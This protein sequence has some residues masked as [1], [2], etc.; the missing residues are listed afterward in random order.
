MCVCWGGGW[1]GVDWHNSNVGRQSQQIFDAWV[2]VGMEP[3][4]PKLDT[5]DM[6]MLGLHD[7]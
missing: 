5:D 2:L 1:P 7:V 6:D 3:S 4:T